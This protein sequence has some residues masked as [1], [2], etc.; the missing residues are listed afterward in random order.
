M[1]IKR[2]LVLAGLLSVYAPVVFGEAH[3]PGSATSVPLRLIQNALFVT[4][5]NVNGTGPYD[6]LVDTGAQVNTID[7]ALATA[8]HLAPES[9]V[10]VSGAATYS[11][12]ALV[13]VDLA[14]VRKTVTA[15]QT[16][17]VPAAQLRAIDPHLRGILGG[18]FLEH[19]DLLLDNQ[20][21]VLC[22]DD[23]ET[24]S[25][26]LKG[27]RIAL[28]DPIA[29]QQAPAPFTRPL[30]VSAS[31]SAF[32]KPMILMLDSGSNSPFLFADHAHLQPAASKPNRILKRYVGGVEQD[33][34]TLPPQEVRINKT[35]VREIQ[36]VMPMNSIG[37]NGVA[38]EEDGVLPT[39][40]Y[41]RV[42][43]SPSKGYVLL[44][45]WN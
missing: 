9:S 13:R 44:D 12:T 3:C 25:S 17:V 33:F 29:P 37:G 19:F 8:L 14:A 32:D 42:F 36:F 6:F 43:I 2:F 34:L 31:L 35:I 1:S 38:F 39:I 20:N 10:G 23:S 28:L 45:P 22:L 24:M 41:R 26:S 40:A 27:Q 4:S 21:R 11:R 7:D 30:V 18:T 5:I 15:S 16:V